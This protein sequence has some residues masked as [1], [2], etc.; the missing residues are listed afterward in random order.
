M[1][2]PTKTQ[3]ATVKLTVLLAALAA[4]TATGQ[5][6]S[7]QQLTNGLVSYYPLDQLSPGTTNKTPDL[8]SRRDLLFTPAMSSA[9]IIAEAIPA[10]ATARPS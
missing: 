7:I 4:F 8:I 3:S 10:W 1:K 2:H 9:N 5:A 6:Q